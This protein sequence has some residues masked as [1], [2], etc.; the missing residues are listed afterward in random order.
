MMRKA[1]GGIAGL[2]ALA[3]CAADATDGVISLGSNLC[4]SDAICP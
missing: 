4:G 2:L 3:P 1:T